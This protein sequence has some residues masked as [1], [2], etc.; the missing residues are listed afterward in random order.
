MS[1]VQASRESE[2]I[3]KTR[4]ILMTSTVPLVARP[5]SQS[6]KSK[7]DAT[8][9]FVFADMQ[10]FIRK[11]RSKL[12]IGAEANSKTDAATTKDDDDIN[13]QDVDRRLSVGLKPLN[14]KGR[15]SDDLNNAYDSNND[16]KDSASVYKPMLELVNPQTTKGMSVSRFRKESDM[17]PCITALF[18]YVEDAID[19]SSAAD[20]IKR[21]LKVYSK[22]DATPDGAD[23]YRRIDIGLTFKRKLP[24]DDVNDDASD[25]LDELD[26]LNEPNYNDMLAVIEAKRLVSEQ[27]RAYQQ[28]YIYTRNVYPE[29]HNRQFVW[30][31]T[32]CAS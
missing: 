12:D 16:S 32:F 24:D 19:R 21:R 25:E 22:S 5:R 3:E 18:R 1:N 14:I 9:E 6:L 23:D 8:A 30:G 28:M 27:T 29:Q 10:R 7:A 15:S 4:D 2:A 20:D 31:F 13:F 17:Y 11:H 26:E